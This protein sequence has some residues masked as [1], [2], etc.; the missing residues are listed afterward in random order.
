MHDFDV[1]NAEDYE[2]GYQYDSYYEPFTLPTDLFTDDEA[3]NWLISLKK[4]GNRV[5][6]MEYATLYCELDYFIFS[7]SCNK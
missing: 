4:M 7:F 6:K 2:Y 1:P 3:V 5:K